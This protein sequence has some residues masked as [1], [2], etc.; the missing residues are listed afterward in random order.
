M[1]RLQVRLTPEHRG[2]IKMSPEKP[3]LVYVYVCVC[4]SVCF[5]SSS[6]LLADRR[7]IL[8]V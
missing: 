1:K 3:E 8:G 6:E 4:V 2:L 5:C 7:W